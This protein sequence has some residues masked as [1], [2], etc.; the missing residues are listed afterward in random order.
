MLH[1]HFLGNVL[2]AFSAASSKLSATNIFNFGFF[3]EKSDSNFFPLSEFVPVNLQTNG[4][5]KST[6][7]AALIIP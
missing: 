5:F 4:S 6:N 1:Y 7:C 3:A 2:T